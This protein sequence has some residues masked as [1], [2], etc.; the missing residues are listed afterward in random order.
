M[1]G[2]SP[3]KRE[4]TGPGRRTSST[5]K[6]R[7][8][9]GKGNARDTGGTAGTSS[10]TGG[11]AAAAG[12]TS[13]EHDDADKEIGA[14][15][16]NPHGITP[17][18]VEEGAKPTQRAFQR[19]I[20]MAAGLLTADAFLE[21]ADAYIDHYDK[22]F[23][24]ADDM[25]GL[26]RQVV[27]E[28]KKPNK[29]AQKRAERL[30]RDA[31]VI[32]KGDGAELGHF[33]QIAKDIS[34]MPAEHI[35]F[36]FAA[37]TQAGLKAFHPDVF[38]PTHSTYNLLHW[39]LA[40]STFQTIAG[41]YG[42]T[43][44]NVSLTVT[45]DYHLLSD[46]YDNF[47]YGTVRDNSRKEHNSPGSLSKSL[48]HSS[49]SKR[50]TRLAD[51]RYKEAKLKGYRKPAAHS[52][53]ERPPGGDA[54]K[55]KG[56]HICAKDGRNP[57]ITAFVRELDGAILKR[58]GR[59]PNWNLKAPEKGT[60]TVPPTPSSTL[61]R[62]LPVGVPIDFWDPQFYNDEF[63]VRE[64]AMYVGT[65]VAF[66]LPQFCT[67]SHVNEW[68]KLPAKEFMA[69]FG[70]DVLAQYNLPTPEEIAVLGLD[71][72]GEQGIE[73]DDESTDLEDTDEDEGM[74]D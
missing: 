17:S 2:T 52:D 8:K 34:L 47:M 31:K 6:Q 14:R 26:M 29:D 3:P 63:D 22:H 66:Q 48:V 68:A 19:H 33:G 20:R 44:L 13:G 32:A 21:P 65:G 39:H 12:A 69:K 41:W 58:I 46:F 10:S 15:R 51:R 72:D 74:E 11:G 25:E 64:K 55:K 9:A 7:R 50:R 38:G 24:D 49:A 42:Y 62:I 57:A 45:Q 28:C 43:A 18:D 27:A 40:V 53:D 59:N 16:R 4:A 30:I 60:V 36:F 37:V 35:A 5:K 1:A 56:L 70:K 23:D 67:D 61:S 71:S 73:G 54:R